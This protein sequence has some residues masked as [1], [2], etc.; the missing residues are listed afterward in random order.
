[1]YFEWQLKRSAEFTL[2]DRNVQL[3]TFGIVFGVLTLFSSSSQDSLVVFDEGFFAHYSVVA[4]V[5]VLLG[6][7]GGLLIATAVFYTD[8]LIKNLSTTVA[9]VL[10]AF[11]SH[12]LFHDVSFDVNL[13]AGGLVVILAVFAFN[14][15]THTAVSVDDLNTQFALRED[16]P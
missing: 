7:L 16:L 14:D 8:T 3:S 2:W 4:A 9:I 10:T 11:T 5:A 13:V 15:T 1:M 12:L 6:S